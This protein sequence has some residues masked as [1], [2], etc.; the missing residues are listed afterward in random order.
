MKLLVLFTGGTMVMEELDESGA[1]G[2]ASREKVV[3]A[4]YR[5]RPTLETLAEIDFSYVVNI[6]S[7]NMNPALWEQVGRAIAES[8]DQYDGFVVIHGTDTMAYTAAA[9]SFMLQNLGK[10]VVLTGAQIPSQHIESDARRN[11]INAVRVALTDLAGVVLVFDRVIISG[12]R[13]SKTTESGLQAFQSINTPPIG[14]IRVHLK[15]FQEMINKRH[16]G[17]LRICAGFERNVAVVSL[18]PGMPEEILLRM[19]DD[20]VKGFVLRGFGTGNIPSNL[21][22]FFEKAQQYQVPVVV[23]T[24][25][26]EGRT[27]ID[28][29]D[30]G[31]RTLELGSI[32]THDMNIEA[33]TTK[34][35]WALGQNTPYDKIKSIMESNLVGEILPFVR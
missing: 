30:M 33:T 29:Y 2:P 12:V 21:L 15:L 1:L 3:N 11:L 20:G 13:A 18:V 7:T 31:K 32:E 26:I 28:L 4:L 9:L 16:S 17:V 6:D 19:L 24:Q 5:L 35:M 22:P 8:Y 34:L 10:P 14:E 23:S 27:L 25:C